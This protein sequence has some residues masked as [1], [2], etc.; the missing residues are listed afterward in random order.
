MPSA[1][2][3]E[4]MSLRL[5]GFGSAIIKYGLKVNLIRVDPKGNFKDGYGKQTSIW[6]LIA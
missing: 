3:I 1:F 4:L 2:F 5:G 6:G